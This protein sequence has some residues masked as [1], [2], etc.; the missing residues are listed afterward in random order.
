LKDNH[1]KRFE[2]FQNRDFDF[3]DM[4]EEI[5]EKTAFMVAKW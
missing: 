2:K 5:V 3:L 1:F 4:F